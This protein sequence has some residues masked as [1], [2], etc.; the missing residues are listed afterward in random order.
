M[1][2][3]CLVTRPAQCCL[4]D[5]S[6]RLVSCSPNRERTRAR[7]QGKSE[8]CVWR[9]HCRRLCHCPCANFEPF[10]SQ[11][12]FRKR[13]Y[14]RESASAGHSVVHFVMGPMVGDHRFPGATTLGRRVTSSA[15]HHLLVPPTGCLHRDALWCGQCRRW[16]IQYFQT[17]MTLR[18]LRLGVAAQ[19]SRTSLSDA[20]HFIVYLSL[21]LRQQR[22]RLQASASGHLPPGTCLR[23][24]ARRHDRMRQVSAA[25]ERRRWRKAPPTEDGLTHDRPDFEGCPSQQRAV[26][27]HER[28][29]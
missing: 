22:L 14:R 17:G 6:L 26:T 23:A 16:K 4:D 12:A 15:N 11:F 21:L 13:G 27:C 1:S 3:Y 7:A 28:S 29:G 5:I 10:V 24:G 9:D 25:T 19:A 2:V 20:P 8:L 18:R